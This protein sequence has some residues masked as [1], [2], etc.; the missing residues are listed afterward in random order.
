MLFILGIPIKRGISEK[1][2]KSLVAKAKSHKRQKELY[3][4]DVNSIVGI[5]YIDYSRAVRKKLMTALNI[6]IP[7]PLNHISAGRSSSSQE[8]GDDESVKLRKR[9]KILRKTRV[10]KQKGK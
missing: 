8:E 5:L 10:K 4:Y 2:K 7:E 6:V 3:V 1:T 9:R